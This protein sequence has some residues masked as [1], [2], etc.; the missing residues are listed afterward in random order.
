MALT[1]RKMEQTDL[2][3]IQALFARVGSTTQVDENS[4]FLVVENKEGAIVGTVGLIR[5]ES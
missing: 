5:R 1:V 2:L 3:A 4:R